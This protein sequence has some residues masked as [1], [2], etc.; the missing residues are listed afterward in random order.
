MKIQSEMYPM[1]ILHYLITTKTHFFQVYV[2]SMGMKKKKFFFCEKTFIQQF[3]YILFAV[4]LCKK[5]KR[6]KEMKNFLS[7]FF[8]SFFYRLFFFSKINMLIFFFHVL[9]VH[10][11]FFFFL[12]FRR[13]KN[14]LR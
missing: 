3:M 7:F 1:F 8:C 6:I 13:Q 14:I 12:P 10:T 5:K 9:N 11:F 2:A 4:C